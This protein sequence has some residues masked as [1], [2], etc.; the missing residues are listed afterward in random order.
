M[1]EV[2]VLRAKD[3]GDASFVIGLITGIVI[4]V[5]ITW[6]LTARPRDDESVQLSLPLDYDDSPDPAATPV[7]AGEAA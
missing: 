5:A 6:V 1:D 7:E 4:G 2:V 3:Q